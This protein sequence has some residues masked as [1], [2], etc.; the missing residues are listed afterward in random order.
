MKSA[1]LKTVK[2]KKQPHAFQINLREKDSDGRTRYVLGFPSKAEKLKWESAV[3]QATM[4]I[5]A[6]STP[7]QQQDMDINGDLN[8]DE[9]HQAAAAAAASRKR[10]LQSAKAKLALVGT[11]HAQ[12]DRAAGDASDDDI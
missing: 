1:T 3:K 2:S 10:K 7:K 9:R 4:A 12:R 6:A 11:A 5:S 8:E